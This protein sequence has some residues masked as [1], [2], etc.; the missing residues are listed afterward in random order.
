MLPM[1]DMDRR[2][3]RVHLE[4]LRHRITGEVTLARDGYRSR[5]SDLLNASERDFLVLTNVTVQP[6]D[7][8]SSSQHPFI[9]VARGQIVF[10]VSL[11]DASSEA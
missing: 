8:G 7:G 11:P 3:E 1:G 9:A 5:L 10:A 6:V 2:Q 4:T